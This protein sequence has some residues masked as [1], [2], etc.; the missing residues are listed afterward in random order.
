MTTTTRSAAK[1]QEK[2]PSAAPPEEAQ[3]G[4]KH[5]TEETAAPPSPKR[6]K[7]EEDGDGQ[8]KNTQQTATKGGE[9]KGDE[10][11]E[12]EQ[13]NGG[14][15]TK[16]STNKPTQPPDDE[17]PASILEKGIIYFFFRPRVNI[18]SPSSVSDIARSHIVLRPIPHGA[19]LDITTNDSDPNT[20]TN[21]RVCVIPKKTLPQTGR[22]RWVGFVEKAG[23]PLSQ[24]RDAFLAESTYETKTAGTRHAPPAAPLAEGVYALTSTGRASHLAYMLTLPEE[25]GDVQRQMGLKER[26]SW[27]ISTKN[28]EFPG[29]ASARLPEAP[30]FPKELLEEFRSLRWVP[31]QPKH[32]DY[33]NAQFLLVGESSGTEKA[34][35]PQEEDEKEG[36]VEPAEEMEELEEE[37]T[38]R[39]KGLSKDDSGRIFADLQADAGDYP[40]LQTTF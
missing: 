24:L 31:T 33:A 19:K 21:T 17:T 4:S 27:V 13:Q 14:K 8:D 32:L 26:G 18:D 28:S 16:A 5:K 29:P 3:P 30:K 38:E 15:D 34:L 20:T 7:K 2:S 22:D 39:M 10:T 6:T 1:K 40:K 25:L 35:A 36:K 11:H 12:P 23:A 37:D 9:T